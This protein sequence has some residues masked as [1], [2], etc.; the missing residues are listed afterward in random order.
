MVLLV[1]VTLL[2]GTGGIHISC[3]CINPCMVYNLHVCTH[4]HKHTHTDEVHVTVLGTNVRY[5]PKDIDDYAS[6]EPQ[7][8]VN[9]VYMI[10]L[11][12]ATRLAYLSMELTGVHKMHG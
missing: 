3:T 12:I 8:A 5:I 1:T 4:T 10:M 6:I 9:K 11:A 7:S 2:G